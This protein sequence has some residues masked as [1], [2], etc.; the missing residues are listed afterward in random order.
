MATDGGMERRGGTLRSVNALRCGL[1]LG[2]VAFHSIEVSDSY[3]RIADTAL[4]VVPGW[5]IAAL[6]ALAGFTAMRSVERHGAATAAI[7]TALRYLPAL[8][9]IVVATAYALGPAVTTESRHS[10]LGDIDVAAY[11]LNI[12]GA[13]RMTL[14]GVFV[15]NAASGV[16]NPIMAVVPAAY[17]AAAILLVTGRRPA[18]QT[19]WLGAIGAVVA[20][21]GV[22]LLVADVDLGRPDGLPALLLAGQGFCA[23]LCFVMGALL[24]RLRRVVSIDW[25]I[26]S[27]V[28]AV[29]VLVALL[30]GRSWSENALVGAATALPIAY[31]A[32]YASSWPWPLRHWAPVAEPVLWRALLLGYPIQ[33]SWIAFGPG[34][35]DA[36]AGFIRSF[37]VIAVLAS[38]LWFLIERPLLRRFVPTMAPPVGLPSDRRFSVRLTAN[39]VGAMLPMIAGALLVILLILAALALTMFAMQR[40]SGGA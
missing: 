3:S 9:I 12:V 30:G 4:W 25:R 6:F 20:I 1:V 38:A 18:V 11:L 31:I 10:Y 36:V 33:Q 16:V 28:A 19:C 29:L 34:R 7:R 40:D 21:T 32:I 15:F 35:Q 37:P 22:G 14:P 2:L 39:R 24:Y 17:G 23:L 8:A 5:T 27:P 13:A 26:A